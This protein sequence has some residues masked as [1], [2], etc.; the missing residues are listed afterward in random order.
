MKTIG[1]GIKIKTSSIYT[2]KKIGVL[3]NLCPGEEPFLVPC[4]N[5]EPS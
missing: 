5:T 1:R 4:E 2:L 3:P